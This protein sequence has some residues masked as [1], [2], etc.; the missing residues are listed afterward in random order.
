MRGG[1]GAR[2]TPGSEPRPRA[3]LAARLIATLGGTGFF[4]FAP[5]TLASLVVAAVYFFLPPMS[6]L[7]QGI[8]L[9]AVTWVGVVTS[10]MAERELGLD[11]HPI[12]ID[13]VAGMVVTLLFISLPAAAPARLAVLLVGFGFFRIFDIFKPWPADRLQHLPGGRGIV[14]DDLMAGVYSNVALRLVMALGL[15]RW[16]PGGGR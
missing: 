8:L 14:A 11:A 7:V 6:V 4:P 12:V 10:T 9:A 5:A 13:E 15:L 3:P 2:G 1:D 16:I